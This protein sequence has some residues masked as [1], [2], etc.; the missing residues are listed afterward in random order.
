MAHEEP[1]FPVTT[2]L[3]LVSVASPRACLWV[4]ALP[5][6]AAVFSCLQRPGSSSQH[7]KLWSQQQIFL[8]RF[9]V[10]LVT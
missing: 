4:V 7:L 1:A 5:A 3:E 9:L 2:G 10:C 8:D 6:M